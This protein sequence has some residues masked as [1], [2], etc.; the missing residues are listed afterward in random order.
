MSEVVTPRQPNPFPH[1]GADDDAA[2]ERYLE[3]YRQ[4]PLAYPAHGP[5]GRS[6]T[7]EGSAVIPSTEVTVTG[8]WQ[9]ASK[10]I[11][12]KPHDQTA[13]LVTTMRWAVFNRHER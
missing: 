13:A 9:P 1:M 5:V 12:A 6:S 3:M 11:D 4:S 8:E 10:E 2:G 7:S